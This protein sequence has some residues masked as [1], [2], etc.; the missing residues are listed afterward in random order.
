MAQGTFAVMVAGLASEDMKDYV[1]QYLAH[2]MRLSRK[3]DGCLVYNVHQS[4]NNSCE[5]MMYSE[6]VDEAAFEE[7]NSTPEMQE[8][9]NELAKAMFNVTSPKTYW[10][11]LPE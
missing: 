4:L 1:S 9:I 8:F 2:M 6:W 3:N 10:Q 5:F 11:L 7:H